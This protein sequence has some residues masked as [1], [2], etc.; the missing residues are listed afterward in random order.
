MKKNRRDFLK[1]SSLAAGTALL[2][3][4]SN[5]LFA[6]KYINTMKS[7]KMKFRF[8]P[9]TLEL[10]HVFTVA[11]ASRSTTPIMLTEIEYDG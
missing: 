6:N 9:Y 8:R 1:I 5:N 2:G 3:G 10:K 7:G 4:I 11:E